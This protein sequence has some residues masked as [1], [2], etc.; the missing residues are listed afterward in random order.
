MFVIILWAIALSGCAVDSVPIHLKDG[1]EYGRINEAFRNRWWNYYERGLSFAEGEFYKEA[2]AD[3]NAAVRQRTKDQRLARTYGMHFIDYFPHR[4]LGIIYYQTQDMETAKRELEIS[5]DH[6][7]SARAWFYLDRVRKAMIEEEGK[8]PT[9]P[10]LTLDFET[11]EIWT[12]DDPVVISGIARDENYI[13]KIVIKGTAGVSKTPAHLRQISEVFNSLFSEG[14]QKRVPFKKPLPLS[15]GRHEI[16]VSTRNLLGK[17]AQKTVVIQVDREGPTITIEDIQPYKKKEGSGITISGSVYDGAGLSELRINGRSVRIR[18]ES[19]LFFT[20]N[21]LTDKNDVQLL[22]SDRLGNQTVSGFRFPVSGFRF[23]V[24]GFRFPVSGFRFPVSGFRLSVV[25]GPLLASNNQRTV[26]TDITGN[27]QLA[28][29]NWQ[30]ATVNRQLT[31]GNRQQS[32]VNRQPSTVNCQLST[33]NRQPVISLKG[34]TDTQTVFLEKIYLEGKVSSENKV[35]SLSVN[36]T[37]VLRRE[38]RYVFFGHLADLEEGKNDIL[39]EVKDEAGNIARKKIAVFRK[40][41]KALQLQE[42][43]SMTVL[44]FEQSGGVSDFSVSFQNNLIN[45][46]V[47]QNRFRVIERDKLDA[48][49]QEHK[50]SRTKLIDRDTALKL[51]RLIAARSVVTGSITESRAGIEIVAR[52][53]DTETSEILASEDVYDEVKDLMALRSLSEGMAV[54]FHRD[55]P[56]V[57]GL[58]IQQKG[59]YIFIDLGKDVVRLRRGF[60]VY[61]EEPIKHPVTGKILGADNVIVGRARITQVMPDL[62]KAEILEEKAAS[63]KPMDKVIAE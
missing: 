24:S 51:G 47:N 29:V 25:K 17:S 15:Q 13:S 61:R 45:A 19:E 40:V 7:P 31:T 43:L 44:P 56:L 42:R 23:P 1:R 27:W 33:G 48:I 21:V 34:W 8:T 52:L 32:T 49:L 54:K 36:G 20:E 37:P 46:L 22:A 30:L 12:R 16:E 11:D 63:V 9:R 57:D 3:L 55:F 18:G 38:G 60:I 59:D 50:L 26:V 6:F 2:A 53:I 28:T 5:L 10:S 41:P 14:S 39:I 4:E 62:S 35:V 58:V